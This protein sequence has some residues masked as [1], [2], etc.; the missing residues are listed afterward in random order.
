MWCQKN[1]SSLLH[2]FLSFLFV[3]SKRSAVLWLLLKSNEISCALYNATVYFVHLNRQRTRRHAFSF[4]FCTI[5]EL[6]RSVSLTSNRNFSFI[7]TL[8]MLSI[9]T[10]SSTLSFH[11]FFYYFFS[12][13]FF[14]HRCRHCRWLRCTWWKK[15]HHFFFFFVQL[16]FLFFCILF[17]LSIPYR[18][19]LFS[20]CVFFLCY[21]YRCCCWFFSPWNL[22]IFTWKPDYVWCYDDA[23]HACACLGTMHDIYI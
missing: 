11:R 19:T 10:S 7:R 1:E 2:F 21:N 12:L 4:S 23:T 5:Y 9:I 6:L 13:L 3:S 15:T 20:R 16:S 18:S 8:F 22:R 17:A 14:Y